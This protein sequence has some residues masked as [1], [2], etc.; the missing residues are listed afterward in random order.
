M[1]IRSQPRDFAK[2]PRTM[3][4]SLQIIHQ[5][6]SDRLLASQAYLTGRNKCAIGHLLTDAQLYDICD[7]GY[8]RGDVNTLQKVYGSKNL[9]AMT[10]MDMRQLRAL[11]ILN[12]HHMLAI[13]RVIRKILDHGSGYIDNVYFS[14]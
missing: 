11:Q 8:N 10:G 6:H 12:D 5:A 13:G 14:C 4:E 1:L 7:D 3:R 2:D 9:K